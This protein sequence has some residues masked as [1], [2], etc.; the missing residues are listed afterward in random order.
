MANVGCESFYRSGW[1]SLYETN[2]LT[3]LTSL[4][5]MHSLISYGIDVEIPR[6]AIGWR[7]MFGSYLVWK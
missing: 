1:D 7:E 4:P 6:A 5:T 3:H 2:L